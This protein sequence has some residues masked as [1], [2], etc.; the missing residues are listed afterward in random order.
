M[1]F[2]GWDRLTRFL[3]ELHWLLIHTDHRLQRIVR[4]FVC[5]QHVFHVRDE[6]SVAFGGITQYS[7]FSFVMRFF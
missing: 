3:D 4:L 6:L 5:F 7:I 2:C 1:V